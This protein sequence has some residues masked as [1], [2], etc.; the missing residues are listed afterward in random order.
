MSDDYEEDS[1]LGID[2]G[3]IDPVGRSLKIMDKLKKGVVRQNRKRRADRNGIPSNK[4]YR[5][6][7]DMIAQAIFDGLTNSAA[8][9]VTLG[10]CEKTIATDRTRWK[11]YIDQRLEFLW[12]ERNQD[13]GQEVKSA[14]QKTVQK[15]VSLREKADNTV[16]TVMDLVAVNPS[17]AMKAAEYVHGLLGIKDEEPEESRASQHTQEKLLA[18]TLGLVSRVLGRPMG[19]PALPEPPAIEVDAEVIK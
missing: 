2:Y 19:N 4:K 1:Y 6:R 3:R 11:K 7:A 18:D 15:M 8:I 17:A 5:L 16:E 10:L 13:I 14:R 9:A 12:A